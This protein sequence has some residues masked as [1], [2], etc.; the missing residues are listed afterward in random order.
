LFQRSNRNFHFGGVSVFGHHFGSF[1]VGVPQIP[2]IPLL[3]EGGIVSRPTLAVIGERG[4][5]AVVPL[6]GKHGM[7]TRIEINVNGVVGNPREVAVT[8]GRELQ[9]LKARGVDFALA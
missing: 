7:G 1:D 3:A 2:K 5:E 9:K 8:I 6:D 4:R